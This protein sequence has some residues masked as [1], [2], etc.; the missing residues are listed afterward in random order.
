MSYTRIMDLIVLGNTTGTS[1]KVYGV[2][3]VECQGWPNFGVLKF[4]G[5]RSGPKALVSSFDYCHSVQVAHAASAEAVSAKLRRGYKHIHW[6][7]AAYKKVQQHLLTT[8]GQ[9]I[10]TS[11]MGGELLNNKPTPKTTPA[12]APHHPT[13]HHPTHPAAVQPAKAT[14]PVKPTV[15]SEPEFDPV[16]E[17]APREI[18]L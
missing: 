7:D 2:V 16:I 8:L 6:K 3:T 17:R 10:L 18:D 14:A 11:W 13:P 4:W 1:D 15:P 12:V 5:P 9:D